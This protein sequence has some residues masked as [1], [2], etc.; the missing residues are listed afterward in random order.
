MAATSKPVDSVYVW[1][2]LPGE[3]DPVVVG[4]LRQH[5]NSATFVYGSSYLKRVNAI[6]LYPPELP[7]RPGVLEPLAGQPLAGCLR[8]G[9]PDTWGRRVIEAKAKVPPNGLSEL[10]YMLLSGSNRFGANDFQASATKYVQ[11]GHPTTLDELHEAA[12][13][14]EA[15]IPLSE[16]LADALVHGTTIGGARP[17]VIITDDEGVQW[18]AKLSASSD[19]PYSLP[20]VEAACM[21]LARKVGI[22]A[23]ETKLTHSLGRDVLLVRR[24]DR[25]KD[26]RTHVVSGLTLG[27]ESDTGARYVT[28]PGILDKIQAFT[29]D[30]KH[31]PVEL[32]R[33]IAFNM[34]ISNSDDHARNH[35]ALWD[36]THLTLSPAFDLGPG[37]RSGDTA[38]QAMAYDR[39]GTRTSAFKPLTNAA[40][41]YGLTH[42]DASDIITAIVD[43]IRKH[44]RDAVA[45]GQLTQAQQ[46]TLWNRQ[47]LNR[48]LFY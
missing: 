10:T 48:A 2:W 1:T 44:W 26:S 8:D 13:K 39:A 41:I 42:N 17:K 14:V 28:Y 38:T 16:T 30:P 15:G 33:R 5:A 45:V 35:A 24:F 36:G 19:Q 11:R 23:A 3:L 37:G 43:A 34:A 21:Y 7:L 18:I 27:G 4:R 20:N 6:S 12:L 9:A 25:N 47:I 22:D 32:F 29:A 46:G 40:R 31:A